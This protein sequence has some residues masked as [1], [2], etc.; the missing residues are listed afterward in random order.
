MTGLVRGCDAVYIEASRIRKE[1]P[2]YIAMAKP[3]FAWDCLQDSPSL[4]IIKQFRLFR[5]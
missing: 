5:F 2:V 1:V 4:G 3:L